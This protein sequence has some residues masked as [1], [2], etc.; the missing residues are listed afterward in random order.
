MRVVVVGGG[1]AGLTAATRLA[2]RGIQVILFE[3]NAYPAHKVCGEYVSNE[4]RDFLTREGLFPDV[5]GMPEIRHLRL[6]SVRGRSVTVPLPLGGFGISR[7]AF[8]NHL[9][10]KAQE[11]GAQVYTHEEVTDIR[12]AGNG[13]QV[14]TTERQLEADYAVGAYGK[15][16]KL[17]VNPP[18][19]PYVGVKYHV[20][21]DHPEDLISL[22]N[23]PGGYCGISK[24]E[25]G[26][27]NLCYLSTRS[28][29]RK[30]GSIPELERSVLCTNP[31]LRNL[32]SDSQFLWARPETINEVSFATKYP[33]RNHVL[34]AG[35]AAGMIAPLAGNGMAIAIHT[36]KLVSDLL[37]NSAF[38]ADRTRVESEYAK[39]WHRLFYWRL[40]RGRLLQ[41]LFG[42][43]SGSEAAVALLQSPGL[44]RRIIRLTHGEP[45]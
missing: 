2:R 31:H 26:R 42:V 43:S 33:V 3:K 14:T 15:R 37:I 6:T 16:S 20:L 29:L 34:L 5:S 44:A 23:F 9:F 27:W 21:T 10:R 39:R 28:N 36:G 4:T 8:D 17:E 22:H 30:A 7:Y 24:V 41:G 12:F 19:S 11:A 45:F 18:R 32:F 1:L 13:F 35:D 40:W 38:D 25:G